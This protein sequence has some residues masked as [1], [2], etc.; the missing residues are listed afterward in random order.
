MAAK[1]AE[2]EIDYLPAK[3]QRRQVRKRNFFFKL[4]RLGDFAGDIPTF[5]CGPAAPGPSW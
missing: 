5:G 2:E 3:A 1:N 4:L